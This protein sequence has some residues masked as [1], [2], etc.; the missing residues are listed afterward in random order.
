M[1]PTLLAV[2]VRLWWLL[3]SDGV[4]SACARALEPAL[5]QRPASLRGM[6][7]LILSSIISDIY[8]QGAVEPGVRTSTC[9]VAS[10]CTCHALELASAGSLEAGRAAWHCTCAAIA[11]NGL[12]SYAQI[13]VGCGR[14]HGRVACSNRASREASAQ[15]PTVGPWAH[16]RAPHIVLAR[17]PVCRD[18]EWQSWLTWLTDESGGHPKRG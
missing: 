17:Q 9:R 16:H 1:P 14:L 5:S 4:L 11:S 6:H 13:H 8:P 10:A 3:C 18:K 12:F 7:V 15:C 2:G